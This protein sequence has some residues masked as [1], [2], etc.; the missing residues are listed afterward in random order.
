MSSNLKHLIV[1]AGHAPFQDSVTTVPAQPELD[2]YWV[3]QSFQIGEPPY[4]I[5][6]IQA[7]VELL[8]QDPSALLLFTGGRT[9]QEAKHWSEAATYAAIAKHFGYWL[10]HANDTQRQN[11]EERIG[12]EL[13]SRDSFENLQFSLLR[14]Q[15]LAGSYPSHISVVGWEFKR[16]RFDLH[17]QT[18]GIP[19]EDFTYIGCNNPQDLAGAVAG[20]KKALE[21]FRKDPYGTHGALLAKR[22]ERNPFNDPIPYEEL[23][24]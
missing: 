5:E 21:S 14:F 16:E 22:L 23:P 10:P 13:H 6:H 12:Q 24:I 4:Y 9:R 15:Q 17:R 3:L 8:G 11:I 1:V 20:E 18:L 2:K 19:P 7:G